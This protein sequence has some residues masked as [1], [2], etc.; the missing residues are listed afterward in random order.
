MIEY[1]P[2]IEDKYRLRSVESARP[3]ASTEQPLRDQ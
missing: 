1:H 3:T 2:F